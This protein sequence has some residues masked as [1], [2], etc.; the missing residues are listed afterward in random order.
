MNKKDV[1]HLSQSDI[2]DTLKTSLDG[3][4][5][6]EA[7][8]RILEHGP[9]IL[10]KKTA[11]A[12]NVFGRQLR[13]SL[14]YLLVV[15]SALSF[16]IKDYTDG[17]I[18]LIILTINTSL[19]FFQEYKSEKIIEKLSRFITKQVRLKRDGQTSL[20]DESVIVQGDIMT[21]REGD[22]VPADMRLIETDNLQVDESQLTGESVP[23]IKQAASGPGVT[24]GT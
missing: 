24:D 17:T 1:L 15:A 18:I 13:S 4:S 2:I 12:L 8:K 19:G 14:V 11:N 16:G 3:L 6:K 7:E 10:G 9:N 22:I 20:L 5:Q 23:V 21:I